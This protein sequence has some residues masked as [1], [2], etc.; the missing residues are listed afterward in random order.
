M[1]RFHLILLII[2]VFLSG[3][4]QKISTQNTAKAQWQQQLKEITQW[5]LKGKV[6]F[7]TK[8][9]KQ[10]ASL[11]WDYISP[12]HSL[13]LT[14]FLGMQILSLN[15]SELGVVIDM[16]DD[17]YTSRDTE[18]LLWQL[19]GFQLPVKQAHLWLSAQMPL[20]KAQYDELNRLKSGS[21]QDENKATWLITY[22]SYVLY[23][24]IW[25]PERLTLKN[26]QISI[27]LQINEW[28]F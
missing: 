11:H 3:C 6:A 27:K 15:E 20:D 9:K 2:L 5:Q 12:F 18:M 28:N 14:S 23:Q 17:H 1:N 24:G 16:G 22:D 19:T 25:L 21:W 8:E 10:S 7:L 13:S 26:K 4:A